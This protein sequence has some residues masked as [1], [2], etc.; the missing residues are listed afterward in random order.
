MKTFLVALTAVI[1]TTAVFA[2]SYHKGW[3]AK[4]PV[5]GD[6]WIGKDANQNAADQMTDH[7]SYEKEVKTKTTK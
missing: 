7:P 5:T 3:I 4:N 1:S 6:I 2:V